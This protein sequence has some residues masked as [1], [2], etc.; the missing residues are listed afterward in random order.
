MI[1]VIYKDEKQTAKGNEESFNL[2]KN[3]RQIGIPNEKYRIYI[4]D[5]V[6]TFLKKIAEKAEE[7]EKGAA[8]VFTGE[9]KWNSGTGYLFIRGALTAEAGEI[10]A[11]HVEF[12]DLTWQK[13]HEETEHYF[14]GQ[15]I[16]G[17]FLTQ[18]SLQMEVTEGVQRI[19]M[20]LFGGEK[21]LMLMDPVEKEEAFFCYDNGR[22]LRQ[23]GYYIYYEKNLQMQSYMIEKNPELSVP[24]EEEVHDDAVRAFR[25]IIQK[26]HSDHPKEDGG[27]T[28]MFSYAATAC[29]ALVVLTVGV[30]FYQNYSNG[31]K[32]PQEVTETASA[33]IKE[34]TKNV[35]TTVTQ[36]PKITE[37][38]K[39]TT[40][41]KVSVT[42]RAEEMVKPTPT[43]AMEQ[44]IAPTPGTRTESE[45]Y[46]EESD[47]RKAEQRVRQELAAETGTAAE[48]SD[49][50]GNGTVETTTG[51]GNSYVIKPGDTLY[52]IS[53]TKYG[54]M[55][56]VAEI[57]Q[58]NGLTEDEIIYP[59]QI[60]VLP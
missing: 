10:S 4:E 15:E 2:P 48:S 44:N 5:Y 58:A 14:A 56:K 43:S 32:M 57:C 1:E 59:G 6:Y 45:I 39:A 19:H 21:V 25:Q 3:I 29:L 11:E 36:I 53:I 54:T 52:Q 31:N 30:Q 42:P 35:K 20:K 26:K 34:K 60:I 17:W 8:A 22:L 33:V 55:E 40:K 9:I 7:E 27:R 46:R 38:P 50:A 28:S 23:S 13:L 49:T 41:P 47:D 12:S 37:T 51:T 18:K 16:I 24:Q